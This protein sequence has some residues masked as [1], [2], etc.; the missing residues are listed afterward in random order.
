MRRKECETRGIG[1]SGSACGRTP[2]LP[3]EGGNWRGWACHS[4]GWG[5]FPPSSRRSKDEYDS[6]PGSGGR[7]GEFGGC[8][9]LRLH[10]Q[11]R[12]RTPGCVLQVSGVCSRLRSKVGRKGTRLRMSL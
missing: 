10:P 5:S 2:A 1:L 3:R 11:D 12:G 7:S 8:P 4:R 6:S 9:S